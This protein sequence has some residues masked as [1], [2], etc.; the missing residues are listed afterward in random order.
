MK[1]VGIHSF[2]CFIIQIVK[3]SRQNYSHRF[4]E[5][6]TD[7]WPVCTNIIQA[8]GQ[9]SRAPQTEEALFTFPNSNDISVVNSAAFYTPGSY[10]SDK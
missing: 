2:I 9:C 1:L 10:M 3:I 7:V 5:E 4:L 8:N 6:T